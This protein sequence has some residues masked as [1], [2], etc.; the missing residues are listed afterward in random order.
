MKKVLSFVFAMTM[1]L[2]ASVNCFAAA[3]LPIID[4]AGVFIDEDFTKPEDQTE[5]ASWAPEGWVFAGIGDKE[6]ETISP[7]GYVE[8]VQ[9]FSSASAQIQYPIAKSIPKNF[10]LMY[11]VYFADDSVRAVYIPAVINGYS[12]SLNAY[13]SVSYVDEN[14]ANKNYTT[15]TPEYDTWYTYVYQVKGD[16]M[17]VFRKTEGESGFTKVAENL[18]LQKTTSANTV[19]MYAFD[20][21]KKMVGSRLDNVKLFSGTYLIDSSINISD[22]KSMIKGELKVGNADIAPTD[23]RN[24]TVIMAAY[25]SKG[26]I[27]KISLN[28]ANVLKFGDN[29]AAVEMPITQELYKNLKGGTV[30][31]F[32]WDSVSGAMPQCKMHILN[33]E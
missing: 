8:L 31:M 2:T 29:I 11:D 32:M 9:N 3:N 28:S 22:D 5:N 7:Q 10:T 1:M 18:Q 33:V 13:G 19:R 20:A 14:G 23:S 21:T 6:I 25:D 27:L 15:G 30:E 4:M 26:K 17:S 16:R 12:L 24:T